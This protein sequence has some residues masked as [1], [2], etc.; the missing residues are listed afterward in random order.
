MG[1]MVTPNGMISIKQ[2]F[3]ALLL[4]LSASHAGLFGAGAVAMRPSPIRT[5]AN[6]INVF[7]LSPKGEREK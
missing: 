2:S 7:I 1:L 3:R 4:L 5:P 6:I